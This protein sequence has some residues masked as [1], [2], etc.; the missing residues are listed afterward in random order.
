VEVRKF[1]RFL[2]FLLA[3]RTPKNRGG[4]AGSDG[5]RGQGNFE[6]NSHARLACYT[7]NKTG[8]ASGSFS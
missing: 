3:T 6:L 8:V 4:S 5:E 1:L 2:I 7:M